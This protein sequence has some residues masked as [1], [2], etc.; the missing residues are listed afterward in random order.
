MKFDALGLEAFV[1]VVDCGTFGKAAVLLHIS[2]TGLSH[3]LKNLETQLG[4]KLIERTTRAWALTPIGEQF[5][6][7]AKRLVEE[8]YDS[9]KNVRAA[10]ESGI[11]SVTV[12][13]ISTT[14]LQAMPQAVRAYSKQF[15][16]NH[17]RILEMASPAVM[18]AVLQGKAEFG[19]NVLTRRHPD[20]NTD[21]TYEE[22]YVLVCLDDHPLS[23]RRKAEW[24]DVDGQSV[25][26]LGHGSANG[27]I[28]NRM[29]TELGLNIHALHET[30][31][32]TTALALASL[33]L[34]LAI[35][36][37]LALHPG[38]YP[39]LRAVPL[40]KPVIKRKLA[41]IRRKGQPLSAAAQR[42]YE[43]VRRYLH[44][45]PGTH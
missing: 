22:A 20:L 10:A 1:A 24:R 29:F 42:L 28:L 35:L 13:T 27:I 21:A 43:E 39:R 32:S 6:P 34:G 9:F 38:M 26:T 12:A 19:I 7:R 4:T 3:R 16:G 37:R 44:E 15:P 31:R 5:Y 40:V 30:Q 23:R 17:V 36:P 8:L 25:I 11:G 33:G 18:E 2:Q 45:L 41:L 14:A